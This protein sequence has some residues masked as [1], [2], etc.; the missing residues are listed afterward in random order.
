MPAKL[1]TVIAGIDDLFYQNVAFAT[2]Y[3]II[4]LWLVLGIKTNVMG[5]RGTF[6]AAVFFMDI[7]DLQATLTAGSCSSRVVFNVPDAESTGLELEWAAQLNANFDFAITASFIDAE[8]KS[9]VTTTDANGVTTPLPGIVSGNPLPTVPET[10]V[11]A[12]GNYVWD[13]GNGWEGF[14]TAVYQYVDER[15]TQFGDLAPGFGTI[16]LLAL[17]NEIGGPLTQDSF[18]FDPVLPDYD[19]INWRIGARNDQWEVAFFV[20]NL[21]DERAFLALD[22][23]RGTLARQGYIINEPRSYGVT[24]RFAF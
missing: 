8:L 2:L 3:F 22:Q 5:G 17:G 24:A 10:Q 14:T 16:N 19:I 6:N 20:D 9:T 1:P 12:A 4:S 18:T 23:E 15:I 13:I 7:E 11:A 21:T